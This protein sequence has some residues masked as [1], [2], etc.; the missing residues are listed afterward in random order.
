[1]TNVQTLIIAVAVVAVAM[2]C[3]RAPQAQSQPSSRNIAVV[4]KT[5]VQ[6]QDSAWFVVQDAIWF[7]EKAKCQKGTP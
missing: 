3:S 4:P 6:Y 2:I 1:M 5:G 7:C